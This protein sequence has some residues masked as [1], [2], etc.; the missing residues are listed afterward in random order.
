MN[1]ILAI[2]YAFMLAYC[3]MQQFGMG[4]TVEDFNEPTHAVYQLG[5]DFF[6]CVSLIGGEETYQVADGGWDN[7]QPYTQSYWLKLEYHKTF[8]EKLTFRTGF[9]HKCQHS[10]ECWGEQ[11]SNFN[12]SCSEIYMG[13]EGKIDLF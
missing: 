12:Y 7:W 11:L 13:I 9:K 5:L 2:T 1:N 4:K 6:D 10:V 3:P 8:N